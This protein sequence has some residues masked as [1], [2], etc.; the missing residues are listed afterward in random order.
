MSPGWPERGRKNS[1]VTPS[2]HHCHPE[3]VSRSPEE[4]RGRI[5]RGLLGNH[6]IR[7]RWPEKAVQKALKEVLTW[8]DKALA[9]VDPFGRV[10][11]CCRHRVQSRNVWSLKK[12]L[13]P[14]DLL[15]KGYLLS[16]GNLLFVDTIGIRY[17]PDA[18]ALPVHVRS[19]LDTEKCSS[20][21]LQYP[22]RTNQRCVASTSISQNMIL[23]VPRRMLLPQ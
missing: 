20:A 6:Q 7:L 12:Y 5:S 9:I 18:I 11:L 8:P 10:G 21:A 3:R 1:P 4:R 15:G 23:P 2:L 13:A 19:P 16:V 14:R 22:H 17:L